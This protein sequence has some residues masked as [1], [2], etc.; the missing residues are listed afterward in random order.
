[1]CN[2][3]EVYGLRDRLAFHENK[4]RIPYS[5]TYLVRIYSSIVVHERIYVRPVATSNVPRARRPRSGVV[6]G[7]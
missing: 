6:K 1:M 3:D 7:Q 5:K 4:Y 2:F